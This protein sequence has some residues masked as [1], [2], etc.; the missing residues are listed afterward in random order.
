MKYATALLLIASFSIAFAQAQAP[1]NFWEPT[2][3]L[4]GAT[5]NALAVHQTGAVFAGTLEGV[6][7]SDDDGDT[8]TLVGNGL[9][10]VPV[11]SFAVNTAGDVFVGTSGAGLFRSLDDG[12][13]WTEVNT[14]FDDHADVVA[15]VI[16]SEGDIFAGTHGMGLYH[17]ID[18][19]QTWTDLD[20]D[21][22]IPPYPTDE[23]PFILTD[24]AVNTEGDVFL[25]VPGGPFRS[26]DKGETW[27][28]IGSQEGGYI[29]TLAINT[30]GD[31]FA[32]DCGQGLFRSSDRGQTWVRTNEGL[33][34]EPLDS[35]LNIIDLALD[36]GGKMFASIATV[37]GRCLEA[38]GGG[39]YRSEDNGETW[40]A[41]NTGL[42]NLS[43]RSLAVGTDGRVFAGT[44]GDGVFRS[45]EVAAPVAIET[46]S[47]AVPQRFT[48]AQNYP[49]P[50]NPSTVFEFD[51]RQAG[52]VTL[53]IYTVLGEVVAT[54]VDEP[55]SAGRYQTQW[56]A[57]GLA[58][59][60]YLYRLEARG[61]VATRAL[62]VLR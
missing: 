17:S 47:S 61:F 19:G 22:R 43:V 49:N 46:L 20:L 39:V 34:G 42:T 40:H 2:N 15:L 58:S 37:G 12:Q 13:T 57:T 36:V 4:E 25:W 55:L 5:V 44:E 6:F 3:G 50:F 21:N 9:P 56:D 41:V 14:G 16:N 30:D 29:H 7:R 32:G 27:T 62:T 28:A 31:V 35:D 45:A 51:V 18:N 59:G 60:V 54:V 23:L 24:V 1:A 33:P 52:A 26:E 10:Q 48:L 11:F 53:R 38:Q 8:W